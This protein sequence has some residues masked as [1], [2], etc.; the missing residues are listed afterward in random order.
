MTSKERVLC[1]LNLQEPDRVPTGEIVIDRKIIADFGKGYE[2][3][4][5]LALGEGIDFVGAV[6]YFGATETFDDGGYIDEWGCTYGPTSDFVAHPTKGPIS[7]ADDL[8]NY[9]LPDPNAPDRLGG[10]EKFVEKADGKISINFHARVAFMWAVFLMGMDKLLMAMAMEPEFVH[11]LFG[12]V[13][14]ANIA[15]IRRAIRAGADTITLGDDYCANKGPMMSP[16]MFREFILPHLT[17][18]VTAIHE[19]GAKVIKHCDGN[20]WPILDMMIESGVDGINPLEP[21]AGMD[22]AEVKEKY[23]DKICIM[24][25]IDCA[26]LLCHGSE[27]EVVDSVKECISKGAKGGGL[28]ISSSNSIHSGVNPANYAAMIKAVHEYGKYPVA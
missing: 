10:L 9:V 14:D 20:T 18:A 11:E 23:G 17:R 3:V 26:E 21:V 1:A 15:V 2:D 25:N 7:C 12:K 22:V 16:A 5:D 4:V 28:I 24:G 27:D 8:K 13:A 6:A 19:E